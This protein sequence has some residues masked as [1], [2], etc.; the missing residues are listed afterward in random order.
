M[1]RADATKLVA[2][3]AKMVLDEPDPESFV[4]HI[5]LK[6]LQSIDCRGA[7]LGVI[8]R[9]GFLD[10]KATYGYSENATQPFMRI[11]LWTPL[12]ITEAVR[13]GEISVYRSTKEILAAFPS[14]SSVP[15]VGDAVTVSAPIIYRNTVIGAFG[16]TSK[17]A[18]H[19]GF[20]K[21]PATEAVLALCAIYVKSLRE[22]KELGERSHAEAVKTLTARQKQIINLFEREL[23]TDQMADMLRYSPSTIKQDIIKIYDIFGVNSRSAVLEIA[24]KIGLIGKGS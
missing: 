24:R 12:P 7:I 3:F 18:P 20:E 8:Q 19:D 11:P 13:T 9:E 17:I 21:E 10:L 15:D 14:L 23:T 6:L 22:K 2:D 5:A 16:F 1:I 4:A